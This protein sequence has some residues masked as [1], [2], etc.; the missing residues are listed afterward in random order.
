MRWQG[1]DSSGDPSHDMRFISLSLV[2]L[3]KKQCI[4]VNLA[5]R[6]AKG[7]PGVGQELSHNTCNITVTLA[8]LLEDTGTIRNS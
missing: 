2:S 8:L 6:P 4:T 1:G 5:H 3:T 7:V